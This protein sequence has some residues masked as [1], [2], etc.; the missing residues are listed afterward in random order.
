H[1]VALYGCYGTVVAQV[2]E[3]SVERGRLR[4]HKVCC[5]VDCGRAI[6]PDG[7]RAQIEGS[8]AFGLSAALYGRIGLRA[9]RVQQSNFHDYRVLRL[10]DMPEVDVELVSSTSALG[11]VGEPG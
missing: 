1:G 8:I 11:G 3:V 6:N 5:A 4:V 9:G 10:R 2:A 7:V